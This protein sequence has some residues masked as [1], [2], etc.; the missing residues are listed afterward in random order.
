MMSELAYNIWGTVASVIGTIAVFQAI[1]RWA[2]DH[3]PSRKV[4]HVEKLLEKT[5]SSFEEALDS[6]LLDQ[7]EVHRFD[8]WL[9]QYVLVKYIESRYDDVRADVFSIQTWYQDLAQWWQGISS[10]LVVICQALMNFR[11]RLAIDRKLVPGNDGHLLPQATQLIRLILG[12]LVLERSW[13]PKSGSASAPGSAR[14]RPVPEFPAIWPPR[15]TKKYTYVLTSGP[16]PSYPATTTS[17]P[18]TS[19]SSSSPSN[20]N[21]NESPCDSPNNLPSVKHHIISDDDLRQLLSLPLTRRSSDL[22]RGVHQL[23]A[24]QRDVLRRY[25]GQLCGVGTGGHLRCRN[26]LG[27]RAVQTG[28]RL[29]P[30]KQRSTGTHGLGEPGSAD[31]GDGK[32][33]AAHG[34]PQPRILSS[35]DVPEDGGDRDCGEPLSV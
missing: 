5:K 8:V 26:H 14:V 32:P 30:V 2:L 17:T 21:D 20:T 27:C 33:A 1:I 31:N 9:A 6:G 12:T 7:D 34:E 10:D 18:F 25:N 3:L 15:V 4:E 35:G 23:D 24:A 13:Y 28:D 16:P 22:E 11:A 29:E 19:D